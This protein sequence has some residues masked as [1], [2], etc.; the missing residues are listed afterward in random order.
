MPT[1]PPPGN[2][3]ARR[4]PVIAN[5]GSGQTS[6]GTG[7]CP[8]R[9]A[10]A[11]RR[12]PAPR[13]LA[14]VRIGGPGFRPC[15]GELEKGCPT[16]SG[17]RPRSRKRESGPEARRR[18][19][20]SAGRRLLARC[21][22]SERYRVGSR[23]PRRRFRLVRASARVAD[24]PDGSPLAR[25]PRGWL[26]RAGSARSLSGAARSSC[27]AACFFGGRSPA[28]A[29]RPLGCGRLVRRTSKGKQS[30]WKDRGFRGWQRSW[31]ART[32]RRSNASKSTW[33]SRG[34]QG[35][36]W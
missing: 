33:W 14:S 24:G 2:R 29:V 26:G 5:F 9:S 32:R 7:S 3:C 12:G 22:S 11:D 10:Q 28:I 25:H 8:R 17:V 16:A 34:A 30:P 15:P 19:R 21:S 18:L 13:N 4:A 23:W 6:S 27:R 20:A 35:V 1:R 31:S 36:C